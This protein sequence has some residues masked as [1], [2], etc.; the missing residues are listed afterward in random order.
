MALHLARVIQFSKEDPSLKHQ[1]YFLWPLVAPY[2]D[3][4]KRL[5]GAFIGLRLY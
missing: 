2:T 1:S 3:V 4:T 5:C